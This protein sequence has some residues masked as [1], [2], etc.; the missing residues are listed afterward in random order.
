[1][2]TFQSDNGLLPLSPYESA[3]LGD[4]QG[5]IAKATDDSWPN[6]MQ[7][8]THY[9]YHSRLGRRMLHRFTALSS[10]RTQGRA[11]PTTG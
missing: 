4:L 11:Q 9:E 7:H 8:P 1:M 5:E 3:E 2:R 10:H 6:C